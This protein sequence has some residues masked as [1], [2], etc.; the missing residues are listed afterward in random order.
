MATAT[1]TT[2]NEPTTMS[3]AH[4]FGKLAAWSACAVGLGAAGAE[5]PAWTAQG[6]AA[7]I[8]ATAS[9]LMAGKAMIDSARPFFFRLM[10]ERREIRQSRASRQ[11]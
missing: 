1:I 11:P 3:T 6:V 4:H 7:I 5:A 9:V 8:G 2:T 10:D